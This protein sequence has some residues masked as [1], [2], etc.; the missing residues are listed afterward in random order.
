MVAAILSTDNTMFQIIIYVSKT[1][2]VTT[3]RITTSSI[4]TVNLKELFS[5]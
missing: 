2:H 3:V 1:Q 5:F 4:F